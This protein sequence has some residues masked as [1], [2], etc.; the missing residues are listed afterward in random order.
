MG[1][2]SR[3]RVPDRTLVVLCSDW[4]VTAL[5]AS[6]R[7]DGPGDPIAIL[8]NDRI[9]AASLSAKTEGVRVGQR[10]REA[11]SCCPKLAVVRRD[12]GAEVRLFES[13]LR[14][15]EVFGAD[16][17]M[18]APG[19]AAF[20]TR[21]PARYFG[22]EARLMAEVDTVCA[23]LSFPGD[24]WRVGVGDGAFVATQAARRGELVAP[25]EGA[26]FLAPF[27]VEILGRPEL[28]DVL[29]RLGVATLADFAALGETEV[30][31]R[32]GSDGGRA[33]R[34]ARGLDDAPLRVRSR[35]EDFSVEQLLDPAAEGVEAMSFVAKGLAEQLAAR[36]AAQGLACTR[37]KVVLTL[38]GGEQLTRIWSSELAVQPAVVAERLRWQLE[39]W[40]L[41]RGRSP[42][43]PGRSQR[44]WEIGEIDRGE[45]VDR[46]ALIPEEVIPDDGRQPDL[47]SRSR[48]GDDRLARSVARVQGML[49]ATA[50][51]RPVPTG[52][53]GP[54]EQIQLLSFSD[55]DPLLSLAPT[56]SRTRPR[57]RVRVNRSTAA[58]DPA[59]APWPG[60]L[61]APSPAVIAAVAL[62]V[63]LLDA[64]GQDVTVDGRG[65]MSAFPTVLMA[66]G[67]TPNTVLSFAGPWPADEHWWE[68]NGRRRRVRLQVLVAAGNAYLLVLERGQWCIEGAYD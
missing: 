55:V 46:V 3:P 24:W 32:F 44:A 2:G 33:H 21:G 15:L 68:E 1:V 40:L 38:T 28:A 57:R 64:A 34:L 35:R 61:P 45:G 30:L 26:A 63:R 20:A 13:V 36:L 60:R 43:D 5:V 11:Q 23:Q 29:R 53:R 8:D 9:I 42:G 58:S 25:G 10:P 17:A 62:P 67:E 65:A 31:A 4:P 19:W 47:W 49:G 59:A 66:A 14:A 27:G 51:V 16:V 39:A 7:G 50:V 52:G 22:G 48:A 54:G 56:R 12:V 41:E 6:K 37:L 18:N